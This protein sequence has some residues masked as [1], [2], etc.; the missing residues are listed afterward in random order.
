MPLAYLDFAHFSLHLF[1]LFFGET[2]FFFLYFDCCRT[3][4]PFLDNE[5]D[6]LA[7]VRLIAAGEGFL[8]KEDAVVDCQIRASIMETGSEGG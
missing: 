2:A 8:V 6:S 3:L 5:R 4:G 7:D 1:L